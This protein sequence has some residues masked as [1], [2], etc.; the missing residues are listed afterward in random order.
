MEGEP[1]LQ[2]V[3]SLNVRAKHLGIVHGMTKVEVDTF[4]SVTVLRR[5]TNDE[6]ATREIL[7]ECAGGFSPRIQDQ[8]QDGAFLCVLD[9]T[10]TEKMFGPPQSLAKNLLVRVKALGVVGCIAV[11]RNLHVAI[12]LANAAAPRAITVVAAGEETAA[13]APLPLIVLDLDQGQ[14]ETLSLWGIHTLGML[15]GLPKKELISRM[16]QRGKRLRLLARGEM[17]YLFQPVEPAFALR[18][19]MELDF[20]VELLDALMFVMN[21]MLEQLILR[22][23]A[24][25]LALATVTIHL[26]LEGGATHSRTVRP[27]LPSNDRQLWLKLLHLD[28]EAHPPAAAIL[29]V[30]LEAEPGSTSKVQLGLFSPQLPE[31]SRLDVTLARISAIVGE[32]NVGRPVLQDTHQADT[33]RMEPFTVLSAQPSEIPQGPQRPAM[34]MLRPPETT[35]VTIQ[36]QLPRTFSFR[37]RRYSVEHAYGPWLTSGEWWTSTLWGCEQWDLVARTQS[38]EM[39]CCCLVRDRMQN[40]WRMVA[41]YD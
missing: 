28:L 16:G 20:P 23:T 10:G 21:V 40:N 2:Q 31:P 18:E 41:L 27:A 15:A 39:L 38:G 17:P 32:G 34:R 8:S 29:A 36:S 22:A 30:T 11:S 5:S 3:A 19:S 37:E 6:T 33:F 25:V 9:I 14:A 26:I 13:L 1:P 7:L 35:F 12:T 24:R 4:P